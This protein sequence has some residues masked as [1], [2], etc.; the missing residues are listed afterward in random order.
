[1]YY[2]LSKI[3]GKYSEFYLDK[4]ISTKS[5]ILVLGVSAPILV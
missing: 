1:M 2:M 5:L 4:Q 3:L